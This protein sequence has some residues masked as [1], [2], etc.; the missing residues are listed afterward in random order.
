MAKYMIYMV[1]A[2]EA[3]IEEVVLFGNSLLEIR[4]GEDYKEFKE[5]GYTEDGVFHLDLLSGHSSLPS[6]ICK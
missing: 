2:S 6:Y 3:K 1:G 4:K 5:D